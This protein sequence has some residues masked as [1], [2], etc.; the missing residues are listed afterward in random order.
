MRM[1]MVGLVYRATVTTREELA[2]LAP[3][4]VRLQ[5]EPDNHHD[6]NAIAVLVTEQKR[7]DWQIGYVPR[8]EASRLAPM[9]DKGTVKIE[10]AWLTEVEPDTGDSE[11][12][13]RLRK[14]APKKSKAKKPRSQAK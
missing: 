3:V 7:R 14:V 8:L 4:K 2:E 9:M 6:P 10:D 11:M 1:A 13:V 12:L 5:R